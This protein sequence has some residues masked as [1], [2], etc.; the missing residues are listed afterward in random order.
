MRTEPGGSVVDERFAGA[1]HGGEAMPMSQALRVPVLAALL[2][3]VPI[4]SSGRLRV[5]ELDTDWQY[6][7]SAIELANRCGGP[8]V[9]LSH[10]AHA[11]HRARTAHPGESRVQFRR[12]PLADGWPPDAPY[13]LVLAWP[14]MNVVPDAWVR[15]CAPGGRVLCPVFLEKPCGFAVLRLTLDQARRPSQAIVAT[16]R[17]ADTA[18]AIRWTLRRAALEPVED[19][20]L[21]R[22]SRPDPANQPVTLC[23]S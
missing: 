23:P 5:L 16:P 1:S 11:I 14:L 21:V 9:S 6:G 10:S 4:Q 15:Q 18:H 8:V 19:G 20:H 22:T 2:H 12:H 17:H 13:D 3:L 7:A